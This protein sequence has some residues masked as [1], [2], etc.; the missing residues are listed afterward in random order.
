MNN[1]LIEGFPSGFP[2]SSKNISCGTAPPTAREWGEVLRTDNHACIRQVRPNFCYP[3]YMQSI[4]EIRKAWTRI[5]HNIEAHH[6]LLLS[7]D[8]YDHF[9]Q[10]H[11]RSRPT[12]R[13]FTADFSGQVAVKLTSV[14]LVESNQ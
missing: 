2:H 8:L 6:R 9:R 7:H 4:A 12:N 10:R 13:L 5:I 3:S 1:E 14:R 11:C